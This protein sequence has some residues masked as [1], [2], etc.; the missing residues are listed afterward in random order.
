[1]PSFHL[2][3]HRDF[4]R[5]Q[6]DKV[7]RLHARARTAGPSI[8]GADV[9]TLKLAFSIPDFLNRELG[10]DSPKKYKTKIK[11]EKQ[12]QNLG[13]L[14]KLR[15]CSQDNIKSSAHGAAI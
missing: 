3:T 15:H 11:F 6:D 5:Q 9:R 2:D 14:G 4:G 10:S 1:V 13:R 12:L 7:K 8:S